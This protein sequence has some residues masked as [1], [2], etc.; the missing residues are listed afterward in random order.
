[1]FSYK[2]RLTSSEVEKLKKKEHIQIKL[3]EHSSLT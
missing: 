1:M 3:N 2:L